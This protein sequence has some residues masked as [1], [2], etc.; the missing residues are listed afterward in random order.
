MI[1]EEGSDR[2]D[3]PISPLA[4]SRITGVDE[5]RLGNYHKDKVDLLLN[6]NKNRN[7]DNLFAGFKLNKE[8]YR[9]DEL[10]YDFRIN[11]QGREQDPRMNSLRKLDA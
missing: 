5:P 4:R 6:E 9:Q 10:A 3:S 2:L 1:K 11:N 7:K 8:H